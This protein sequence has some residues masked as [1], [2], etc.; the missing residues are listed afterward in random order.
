MG[1]LILPMPVWAT[2]TTTANVTTC[3][4][5]TNLGTTPIGN[6]PSGPDN[7]VVT[8]SPGATVSAGDASAIS[9][10]DGANVT[11]GNNAT[12]TSAARSGN[13]LWNAGKNTVEFRSNGTLTVGTGA[14][15][16]ATGTSTNAEAVNLLG[17][18]NTVINHGTISGINSAAIWFEDTV[19]GA[20]NTIDNYGVVRTGNGSDQSIIANVIGS[21]HN[22]DVHFTNRTGAVVYGGLSFASGNDVLTLYPSS[23]VTGGFNGGGG[24]NTLTLTGEAG[25]SDTLTGGISNF[26]SLTKTGPGTWTLQGSVGNNGG[27]AALAV[28]VQQGTLALS[29]D[30]TNFNG[31]VLVDP[32]GTLEARAQSL[33]PDVTDNGLVRFVQPDNGNYSGTISGT[34]SVSKTAAGI[35]TLSGTNSYQGGTLIQGGAIAVDADSRLG[36]GSGALTLDGGALELTSSFDLSPS[37]AITVTAS[38]GTIQTDAGVA[39]TVSQA[40]GGAGALTKAGPGLLTLANDNSYAGGTTIGNGTLQLGNGGTTGSIVGNVTDNGTLA[41][42]RSDTYTFDGTLSGSGAVAQSGPGV[43]VLTGNNSYTG[44]TTISNGWLYVDGDQSGATGPT[45][46]ASGTRLAG[47]GIVGGNVTIA[48]GATLAP[49]AVPATSATLTINGDL[50]L[51]PTS[52]LFYNMQQAN[53]AGGQLNDLAVVNGNLTLDGV[54]NVVDQGQTLGAGIYRVFDYSGS[55]TDNGLQIGA[56]MTAPSSPQDTATTTRPLTGFSVQTSIAGQVNLVNTGG[57]TLNY[58]DVGPKNNG[59]VNGGTGTWQASAGTVNDNWTGPDGA[60]NA[61]WADGAF[62]IFTGTPGTVTIDDSLGAVT[63]RGM[64]F[65][66]S[67]YTVSGDAITLA[68]PTTGNPTTIRVGDG[69]AASAGMTATVNAVLT[70]TAG[71]IK[72]DLGTLVLN[73]TDSYTGGTFVLG[74][75]LQISRDANLGAAPT[76]LTLANGSTLR[77]T[78]D[79][80]TGRLILLTGSSGGAPGGTIETASGSQFT[81]NSQ[82]LQGTQAATLTKTGDGTLVLNGG[83]TYSGGTTISAGTL[84]VGTGGT[85]GSMLGN[86][87]DNG[88]LAFDRSDTVTFGGLIAGSGS[89]SQT[90]TGTT[91]L[92]NNDTYAGGT[93]IG[94]GT[95]Q[96]GNGG[97]TGSIVGNVTDNGALVFDRSDSVTFGGTI[98]G[99][100]SVTQSGPGVTVLMGNNSYAGATTI[101]NGW[102]YVDGDQSGATGPTTAASGTRL[103]GNGIV[104]GNVTIA[105]GA[106]LAPGAVPTTPATLTIN[107]DL[108]LNP[109]SNLFYNMVQANVAGGQLNDLTNVNGN[110]VLDGVINVADQGQTLGAGVYRVINYSGALTDNGLTIG[111]YMTAPASPQD[112]PVTTAPLTGFSV[113]TSIPGQVNLVNTAGLNLNYWDGQAGPKNNSAINGGNGVWQ[114]SGG[115]DNWTDPNGIV[116]ASWADDSYAIFMGTPGTVTVDDTTAGPVA[117]TGMQFASDGYVVTGGPI[118]L[119]DAATGNVTTIRVGDGTSAGASMTATVDAALTGSAA[120]IKDDLGTLVLNGTNT[121]TGGTGIY[122]GTLQVSG[123]QNLGAANGAVALVNGSTLSTTSTFSTGRSILL[124]SNGSG[125]SGGTI[126]TAAGTTLTANGIILENPSGPPA[127]LQKAG[128]GT[129]V[130]TGSSDAYTGGTTISA[131]TLQLGNGGTTGAVPGDVVD[132]GILA[133]DRSDAATFGGAVS[134]TGALDQIGTGT[135]VLTNANTYTGGTTITSGALQ[136]GNGGTTGSIVGDVTDNG[137][138]TFDRSDT[139]AFDGVVSGSGLL[140]QAGSGTTVLTNSNTYTGGTTIGAGTLQL[141]DGGTT[142]SIVGDVADNGTLAFNRSDTVTFGGLVSGSG[143]LN[144]TGT[145]A[146]VLTN[147]DTY[148]GGTTISAGAL[149]IGAGGTTGSI[150]GDVTDNG[151]LIFDRLDDIT[152]DGRIIGSGSV[153][154]QGAGTAIFT[155]GSTYSGGTT[156]SAGTLQ[157]GDGGNTGSIVG[158]IVNNGTLAVDHSDVLPV[159]G[160]VSGS[161]NVVQRG[162]GAT[163]LLGTNSY[164]GPTDVASGALY[165]DGDQTA[166]TG[167]TTAASGGT[168]GGSGIIGGNVD[169]A[170]GAAL[171]PGQVGIAP[172]TLTINGNLDLGGG[173]SLNYGLGQANVVGGP[174]NDLTAV[175]GNLTLGGTLNVETTEGGA[176]DPGIYRIISYA[177]SLA[178][179]GLA[180]GT[181]PSPD[182][183]VQTSVNHQVNLVN[184]AGM[185]FSYWDGVAGPKD[186]SSID[187]GNGTWQNSGGN[188]NWTDELGV[189]NAPFAD[190]TFAIFTA[191]PGTVTVDDSLGAIQVAG[192]QFASDGY[193]LTGG[194]VTLVGSSATPGESI[195]RVGDGTSPGA[196]YVA[197]IDSVLAGSSRLVKSDLGTLVLNAPNLYTGGT[198][199]NGGVLQ[200]HA[201]DNLGAS[202][203]ALGLDGGTL[204]TTA[205]FPSARATTLGD[206]G[207]TFEPVAGT[208]FTLDS[209]VGGTGVLTK[210]G[211]GTLV[212]AADN[213]YTNRTEITEGTLQVGNGG[214]AGSIAGNVIDDGVLAFNRSDTYTYAGNIWGSGV[215]EQTGSGTTVMTGSN[216]YTGP[217]YVGAGTLRAGATGTF[218]PGSAFGVNPGATLDLNGFDQTVA[219]LANAGLVRIGGAPGTTLRV[220]G[221][222]VGDG[223]ALALNTYLGT[224]ASPSDRLVIDGGT[225]TGGAAA[226]AI[227]AGSRAAVPRAVIRQAASG[228]TSILVSNVGGPGARTTGDGILVVDAVNGA[229]TTPTAFALGTPAVAGP[230]EYALYRGGA[231]NGSSDDWFLRSALNCAASPGVPGCGTTPP[232]TPPGTTPPGTTPPSAVPVYRPETS[233]YAAIPSLALTYG[234]ALLDSL[235]ERMGGQA[236]PQTDNPSAS[237]EK[238]PNALGW[239]RIVGITGSKDGGSAGIYGNDG[240]SYDYRMYAAQAGMDVYR[241]RRPDNSAD[242]AGLYVAYGEIDGDVDHFDGSDAGK[243]RIDGATLGAYWT[244]FGPSGWYVDNVI[245]GTRY[246]IKASGPTGSLDSHGT[247]V[248]A[249]VEGGYPVALN[250]GF[251]I[252][253]QAQLV[254]QTVY[255]N[256][257]HDDAA[258]VRFRDAQSLMARFGVRFSRSWEIAPGTAREAPRKATAWVRA[259]FIN[260][261]LG[262]PDTEFSSAD[263]YVPFQANVHGPGAKLDAGLD[264]QVTKRTSVY[265]S[266][267]GQF[268]GDSHSVGAEA[269]IKVR[270]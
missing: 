197:T 232:T 185:A 236:G 198:Q 207:G 209:G 45:T 230:Y 228:N 256:S 113:Q 40:I 205:T 128:D 80:S 67:G 165:V 263:G 163:V 245:Q 211:A 225:A 161:G 151:A 182:Y 18:G 48:D 127:T 109:T 229:T 72:E 71:L 107:G 36:A 129:L 173:S 222:Y 65:A 38:D 100:G 239:A 152:Y 243:D 31:T 143:S 22:G 27:N 175:Q 269:G 148:T 115:N 135:T 227:S 267:Q 167:L 93:T 262:R 131:G 241:S 189:P 103:A 196:G 9:L 190:S 253:P 261:F 235:H 186:N 166:A 149:Q 150:V 233:L 146:T 125:S 110:L 30:N 97:T 6:G 251:V 111:S 63:T 2:C 41:F 76:L 177:G 248:G 252:E 254:Y 56:Y 123:D 221:N 19:I 116:N 87:V 141:G 194:P 69:T 3:S 95:L 192:M 74:G 114:A 62:G 99:S 195:I 59:V 64:Q 39:S 70:G 260:E 265:G 247:G 170:D 83:N 181:I 160:V 119:R 257:T 13:G 244:H 23:V 199:V 246:H 231:A 145:G 86:V 20:A 138:L 98:S 102:L 144:Q 206:N 79:F 250:N 234:S 1:L 112:V 21:Q 155:G 120:L 183:F 136:L 134:G 43:T 162:S 218:S 133:F 212:F 17:A 14:T 26:Q 24:T 84:Q 96:L 174:L 60:I 216:S 180:I 169:I 220:T 242:H 5:A 208:T 223:G 215:V 42:N 139:V 81:V 126:Q 54:I 73:G 91:V 75:T 193:V 164:S 132:N 12:V 147:N 89:L 203:S 11:V 178:N 124:G 85:T 88:A 226:S 130:L 77:T 34:G 224:D 52:N 153:V 8:V 213:T 270:F 32:A 268:S 53:V 210:A 82:I 16:S 137:T 157:L 159:V 106:T 50:N 266:V 238:Q 201:D 28:D 179:N 264:A 217:T 58:W 101:S 68:A 158:D 187:G 249:S 66:T 219:G 78:A 202:G 255:L 10:R 46:A 94:S 90:G 121:Y 51:S 140:T 108:D 176:F 7:A 47:N 25:S 142:G 156:I 57:L 259:S 258:D 122:G 37:R 105:D 33:P 92:T 154:K 168:L 49:G 35:L 240:P 184:T 15:V 61:P 214:T 204:R 118:T 188:N 191:A 172:G 200:V 171:A 44:P 55:L 4:G 104:G 117:A 29:G 237:D